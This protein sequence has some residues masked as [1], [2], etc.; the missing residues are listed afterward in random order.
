MA[1]YCSNSIVFFSKDKSKLSRFLRKVY[2]AYD[3]IGSGFYN[4]MV[5][6]GYKNREILSV[7]DKRDSF[8]HCDTKLEQ[9]KDTYSFKVEVETAW[10]PHMAMFYKIIREKYNN[11]IQLVY[12]A[13]ECGSELYVNSDKEGVYFPERYVVDC[14]HNGEYLNEYFD[15]YQEAISW[16]KTEY[17]DIDINEYNSLKEVEMVVEASSDFDTGDFFNFH[18]FETEYNF[19]EERGAA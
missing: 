8:T 15:T 6:H 3:S 10:E 19:G 9:N 16:I 18:R 12:M 14:C 13:E 17:G 5:L 11:A 7:I 4:L 1:N 2:A